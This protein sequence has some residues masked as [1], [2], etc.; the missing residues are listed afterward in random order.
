MRN[1]KVKAMVVAALIAA[2]YTAVGLALAPI[3]FGAVQL[4][5][6]EAFTLLAVF[7]PVGVWGISVGCLLTNLIGTAMGVT[8]G[9]DI[10][11]GTLATVLAG[12]CSY[13]LRNARFK[14]L[15]VLSALCPVVFN[16][17]IVGA[18]LTIIIGWNI[19]IFL[20][21]MLSVGIGEAAACFLLGLPLVY[22]LERAGLDQRLFG[23]SSSSKSPIRE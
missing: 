21:N 13:A 22:A 12:I 17:L 10:L 9:I 19:R 1:P 3:G 23:Q 20:L 7:S 15:P 8:I 11:V 14:G 16:A 6:A 4:R 2:L 5:V 18:E